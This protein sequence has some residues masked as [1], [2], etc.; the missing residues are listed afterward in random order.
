MDAE[1]MRNFILITSFSVRH[2]KQKQCLVSVKELFR[3]VIYLAFLSF[4]TRQHHYIGS[5][6]PY[7]WFLRICS[8]IKRCRF[9]PYCCLVYLLLV[10]GPIF[11]VLTR[12]TGRIFWS[13]AEQRIFRR[14]LIA[15]FKLH[16][17]K[18]Q[19]LSPGSNDLSDQVKNAQ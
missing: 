6:D 12:N 3:F 13:W 2:I 19:Y 4:G 1:I 9:N 17:L 7:G 11:V 5:R 8:N 16:A 18:S 15:L 14:S 10:A